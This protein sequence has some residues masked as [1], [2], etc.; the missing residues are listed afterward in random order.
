MRR[1]LLAVIV[2]AVLA[3]TTTACQQSDAVPD[4]KLASSIDA[5]VDQELAHDLSD[6]DRAALEKARAT[7]RI[8]QADYLE[9][10][11][12]YEKCM[13][14]SGFDLE[15]TDHLN[16]LVEFQPKGAPAD[17]AARDKMLA[18]NHT[19][20]S[21]TSGR[22]QELYR[23]Q[24][25]NPELLTDIAAVAVACLSD[26]GVIDDDFTRDDFQENV[27]SNFN[28]DALPFDVNDPQ[29]QTCFFSV[30]LVRWVET[31]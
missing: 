18:T 10:I 24:T 1:S 11:D 30:G 5:L 20:L 15:R 7:G 4:G 2:C 23:F 29:V 19:C 16:G 8:S 21:S 27:I 28:V 12:L 17:D 6:W 25:G 31:E 22:T 26:A 14:T 3:S 9:G 13:S